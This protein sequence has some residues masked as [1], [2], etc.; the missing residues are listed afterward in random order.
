MAEIRISA[1]QLPAALR[2][3]AKRMPDAVRRGMVRAANRGVMHLVAQTDEKG[4]TYQGQYK[5]GFHAERTADGARIY[6]DAPHAGIIELGARPHPVSEEG[7]AHIAE[8]ARI[9]LGM[10]EEEAMALARGLAWKLRAKGQEGKFVFRD[11]QDKLVEILR[12][13]VERI[14]REPPKMPSA[15]VASTGPKKPDN[16]RRD[17]RGKFLKKGTP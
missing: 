16:R 5:A 1:R 14:L 3:E 12:E 13:E 11:A 8:W 4:L 6:N 9:K 7:I 15:R 17:S 10:Q 2:R